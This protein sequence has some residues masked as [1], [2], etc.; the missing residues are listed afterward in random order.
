MLSKMFTIGPVELYPSTKK[1]RLHNFVYFRTDE[2]SEI[3]NDS[4]IKLSTLLGNSEPQSIIYFA[5]SGTAVMEAT[6]E[7]C[8]SEKDKVLVINGGSFGHRFCDIL[9]Y[10][11]KDYS[12]INL[13]WNET[14]TQKHLDSFENKNYTMLFVNLHETQTGQLYDIKMLSEFCKRNNMMLVVDAIS[15]FLADKYDME[16]YGIDLTIISS[17]KGLCLSPGM[18]FV[19]FSKRM[20]KKLEKMPLPPT[21]YF[22]FKDYLKNISRG[23]TPYT[24]PVLLIY[25]LQDMLNVIHK[26]GGLEARLSFVKEKAEYFR[27][28]IQQL[29]I[30]IP[31]YPLSYALTPIYFED[32]NAYEI[33]QE[34]KNK[35]RIFINPCS[36]DL[37]KNLIRVAHIG[38]TTIKDIDYLLEKLML[39][40]EN[41]KK[42]GDSVYD[43]Q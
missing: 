28:R 8:V 31:N 20:I 1:V 22:D 7:N 2:F 32:V 9:R 35:Y 43:R 19:S 40:I 39:S 37:A 17:Q 18:S 29:G 25:E 12:S 41:V 34:L 3:V 6:V 10:H 38:N 11:K 42:K 36:G 16:R 13:K 21:K 30:V 26:E 14:L 15:T 33:F 4:L 5:A 24:P 23:Q 27:K